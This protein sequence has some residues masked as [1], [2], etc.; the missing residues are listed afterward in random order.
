MGDLF[1]KLESPLLT[2]VQITWPDD[3]QA[4][5]S[6]ADLADLYA[7]EPKIFT[8]RTTLDGGDAILTGRLADRQWRVK[9][10]LDGAASS[11]GIA[12]LWARDRIDDL[13]TTT[14]RGDDG[15]TVRAQVVNL[16]LTHSLVTKYTSLVA[17]D[18]TPTRP[19]D[20][21]LSSRRSG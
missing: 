6:T 21:P 3:I 7:G 10:P 18:A 12:K 19:V 14:W 2:N 20:L 16:G 17:V 13:M 15:G 11:P 1:A 5:L 9:L 4:E 8:I